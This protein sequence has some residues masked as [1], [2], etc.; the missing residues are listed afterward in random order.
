V[1][2]EKSSDSNFAEKMEQIS[3]GGLFSDKELEEVAKNKGASLKLFQIMASGIYEKDGEKIR[4][5]Q[6]QRVALASTLQKVSEIMLGNETNKKLN[7]TKIVAEKNN[8]IESV[9]E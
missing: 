9:K 3:T 8:I 5:T 6:K 1:E 7:G 4:L 2:S